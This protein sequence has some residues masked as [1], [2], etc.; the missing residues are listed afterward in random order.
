MIQLRIFQW[1]EY[2]R[3]EYPLLGYLC[4]TFPMKNKSKLG[5]E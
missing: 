5:V 3:K 2:P 1:K 4:Y